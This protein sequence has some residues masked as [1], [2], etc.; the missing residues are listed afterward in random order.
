MKSRNNE[1]IQSENVL[2]AGLQNLASLP[3]ASFP[4]Q[5]LLN[6]LLGRKHSF[7]GEKKFFGGCGLLLKNADPTNRVDHRCEGET[8]VFITLQASNGGW[9]GKRPVR[10]VARLVYKSEV[11]KKIPTWSC[12]VF[13]W[14][15]SSQHRWDRMM[16]SIPTAWLEF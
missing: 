5:E 14:D 10:S 2:W 1:N 3:V 8:W 7:V 16:S 15:K 13:L 11:T 12:K 9:C 6:H 4:L